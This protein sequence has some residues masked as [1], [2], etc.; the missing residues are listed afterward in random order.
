MAKSTKYPVAGSLREIR[1][2]LMTEEVPESLQVGEAGEIGKELNEWRR[3]LAR[4]HV[5]HTSGGRIDGWGTGFVLPPPAR[6]SAGQGDGGQGKDSSDEDE[7][8]DGDGSPRSRGTAGRS[9]RSPP[10]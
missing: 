1:E 6:P 5:V 9:R 4:I 7:D 2:N 3:V 8:G 10:A